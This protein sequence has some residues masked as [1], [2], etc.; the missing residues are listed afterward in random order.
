MDVKSP[1]RVNDIASP[2]AFAK[3]PHLEDLIELPK[4]IGIRGS[5]QGA[6]KLKKPATN[7][8]LYVMSIAGPT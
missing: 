4:T 8:R 1:K 6:N 3:G 2:S 5:T 7:P